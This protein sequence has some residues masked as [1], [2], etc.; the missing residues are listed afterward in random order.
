MSELKL[1]IAVD[2]ILSK[3]ISDPELGTSADN[4]YCVQL[5]TLITEANNAE[6]EAKLAKV[7]AKVIRE[8]S[9][10]INRVRWRSFDPE[11][12]HS[13]RDVWQEAIRQSI[14]ELLALSKVKE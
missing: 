2:Q 13:H 6:W 7:R 5:I 1:A 10:A 9:Y 12:C 4:D 8:C 3:V 14:L 11:Y